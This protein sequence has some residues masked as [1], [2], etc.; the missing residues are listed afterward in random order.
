MYKHVYILFLVAVGGM[1]SLDL[2]R[3]DTNPTDP[4]KPYNPEISSTSSDS[5]ILPAPEQNPER[6]RLTFVGDLMCH[7]EQYQRAIA[8]DGY[9]FGP[10]FQWV[11]PYL[12]KADFCFGNLETTFSGTESWRRIS[13]YPAFNTPDAFA[14]ALSDAGFDMVFMANNHTLDHGEHGLSRSLEVLRENGLRQAGVRRV[15]EERSPFAILEA[16]G[17]RLAVLAYTAF[18]NASL[19]DRDSLSLYL[20]DPTQLPRH[21]TYART[22][23]A[24]I[25]IV[26]FHYGTEY[27]QRPTALQ[28][29]AVKAA[30]RAGADIIVGDHPHVIQPLN[31]FHSGATH[32]DET[33]VAY[34]LG[35]FLSNQQGSRTRAGLMLTVEIERNG[36]D[37]AKPFRLAK[38]EVVPTAVILPQDGQHTILPTH[39]AAELKPVPK[40]AF[41]ARNALSLSD[42]QLKI[43]RQT[44]RD[45]RELIKLRDR[46]VIWDRGY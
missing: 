44:E 4:P 11:S 16:K 7:Q 24:D 28:L 46:D 41:E 42:Y 9:D 19:N 18:S 25:V 29:E 37:A 27:L 33:L 6:L 21:I 38:V 13:G 31:T 15:D 1:A 12:Q 32:I 22:L 35:N 39:V 45:T 30:V 10:S 5:T 40:L 36:S 2:T 43:L 17:I 8:E 23:G 3:I 14:T 20:L 26:H 34:S